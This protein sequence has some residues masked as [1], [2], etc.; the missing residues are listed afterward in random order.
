[1][2]I[3]LIDQL[4]NLLSETVTSVRERESSTFDQLAAPFSESIIL[5]GAGGLGRKTLTGLRT[6]GIEPLGFADNNPALWNKSID[7]LHVLSPQDAAYKFGDTAAFVVTIWSPGE[8]CKFVYVKQQLLKLK[9]LTTA[10]FIPLF[11][12]YPEVF[13][14]YY[15]LDLP[16]KVYQEADSVRKAFFLL[17]DD[18]SRRE[19][20]AQLKWRTLLDFDG[21]SSPSLQEQYFPNDLFSLTPDDVFV[22]CGAFDGDTLRRFIQ[23]QGDSF[24]KVIALEPDP[25]NFQNLQ[26]YVSTLAINIRE[27]V[28]LL[29]LAAGVRKEKVYFEATG[30]TSSAVL[31]T[32]TFEVES[33]ALDEALGD[34]LPTYIKMDIEGAEPDALAGARRVISQARPILAISVYHRQDHLWKIPLFIYSLFSQYR[35]VLLPH[36]ED[37]LELVCYAVPVERFNA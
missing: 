3:S 29:Q 34:C 35:F 1:M 24:G 33:I 23:R 9:C 7:G 37:G 30:T 15:C 5:F 20:L 4:D 10:S 36:C 6:V 18:A 26:K 32:S 8:K 12:K 11:W 19:Y 21:L 17:T 22:D 27:K 25:L 16:H 31:G 14:P 2:E 13:L 28:S